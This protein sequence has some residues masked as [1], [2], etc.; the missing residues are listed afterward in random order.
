VAEGSE[1]EQFCR[2]VDQRQ[3]DHQEDNSKG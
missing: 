1:P 2:P 3:R